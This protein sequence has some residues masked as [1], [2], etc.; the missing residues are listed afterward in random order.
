VA[1]AEVALAEVALAEVALAEVALAEVALAEVRVQEPAL[2][3]C[4]SGHPVPR[5][6][7]HSF[8]MSEPVLTTKT[9][10]QTD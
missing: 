10:I 6:G 1:L 5:A 2:T 7:A 4:T 9:P 3:G 8:P